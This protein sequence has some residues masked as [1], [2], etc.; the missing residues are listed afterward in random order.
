MTDVI[1]RWLLKSRAIF[2]RVVWNHADTGIPNRDTTG[3]N[4]SLALAIDVRCR[5]KEPNIMGFAGPAVLRNRTLPE[6]IVENFFFAQL[7]LCIQ[8][9]QR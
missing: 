1:P 3:P 5:M 7:F 9:K 6:G 8:P 2:Y 4:L